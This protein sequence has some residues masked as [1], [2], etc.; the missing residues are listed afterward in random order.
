MV[1]LSANLM[2]FLHSRYDLPAFPG[3][4]IPLKPAKSQ[5][6]VLFLLGIKGLNNFMLLAVEIPKL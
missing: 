6:T 4:R 1:L 2:V 3:T 5:A